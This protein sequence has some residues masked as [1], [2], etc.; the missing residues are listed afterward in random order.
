M[1]IIRKAIWKIISIT[2]LLSAAFVL[3]MF[4]F[5]IWTLESIT[6]TFIKLIPY[7]I[8]GLI[9]FW[10][11]YSMYIERIILWFNRRKSRNVI[12]EDIPKNAQVS[13]K[14]RSGKD[15]STN[16]EAILIR[17]EILKKERI[18]LKELISI[19][20]MYDINK[21]NIYLNLYYK[22]YFVASETRLKNVFHKMI[23]KNQCF[24]N[25]HFTK[26]IDF[27]KHLK[28][29]KYQ[30]GKYIPDIPYQDGLTPGGKH[31]LDLLYEYTTT[32]VYH[33]FIKNFMMTN[34]P[35]LEDYSIDK[36]TGRIKTIYSKMFSQRFF[37]LK[38]D[39]PFPMPMRG[40]I[41]ETES[42]SLYSN[43]DNEQ[44]NYVNTESGIRETQMFW[45][46]L[47]KEQ[48]WYRSITQDQ[49]RPIKGLREL[50]EAYI[51]VFKLKFK[52]TGEVK[53]FIYSLRAVRHKVRILFMKLLL[54]IPSPRVSK[55][56]FY[57]K[58]YKSK[59]HIS[60]LS[61]KSLIRWSKGYIIF[62]KGIYYNISDVGKKVKFPIFGVIKESVLNTSDFYSFGFK[63][64]N[65][66]KDCFGRYDTWIMRTIREAKEVIYN[67]HFA[68]VPEWESFFITFE[69]LKY[70]NYKVFLDLM[71]VAINSLEKENLENKTRIKALIKKRKLLPKLN[72]L[73]NSELINISIDFGLIK[74]GD[75]TPE[76]MN[77]ERRLKAIEV[78]SQCYQNFGKE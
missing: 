53:R 46:H 3:S 38:Q 29:W 72:E 75:Y 12:V 49:N 37:S 77:D 31:Y 5:E 6:T 58:I 69:N 55:K 25:D 39:T 15:S 57:K 51:H 41:S 73:T 21:V 10:F 20:Y 2:I 48:V 67:E 9:F 63:Q 32:Y 78:L 11:M 43:T 36:K 62:Y 7:M 17:E 54:K 28:S 52:S 42:A 40:F 70:M 56:R 44:K 71:T 74:S 26:L 13:G 33:N 76:D 19:M 1:V 4:V 60:K 47:F 35:V 59:F 45:G 34:Q 50:Y 27:R 16:G 14:K 68:D 61:Q 30:K 66:I 8:L 18:R 22:D 64:T 65:R 24:I 23:R